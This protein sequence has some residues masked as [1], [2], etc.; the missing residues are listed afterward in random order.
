MNDL[1]WILV[2]FFVFPLL[3]VIVLTAFGVIKLDADLV[4]S[5]ARVVA[6]AQAR[7]GLRL[8][9]IGRLEPL[10]GP[11]VIEAPFTGRQ[12]LYCC[13]ELER[14]GNSSDNGSAYE[15][16]VQSRQGV[17]WLRL[18]DDV[19]AVSVCFFED[20]DNLEVHLE[21]RRE[22]LLENVD[23]EAVERWLQSAGRTVESVEDGFPWGNSHLP[24]DYRIKQQLIVEGE[25]AVIAGMC[26]TRSGATTGHGGA[27]RSLPAEIAIVAPGGR[28]RTP[29]LVS[30]EQKTVR[31]HRRKTKV[32]PT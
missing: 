5:T 20:E 1:I 23:M 15:T 9:L 27:Y 13:T 14:Y 19:G 18:E 31:R 26:T 3:V 11:S 29:V 28:H 8:K 17:G 10:A 4:Y 6:S 30:T 22:S 7:D 24:A 16:I 32:R 12:C 21:P 2:A 25:E